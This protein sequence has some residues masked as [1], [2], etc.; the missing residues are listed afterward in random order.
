[1]ETNGWVLA[2]MAAVVGAAAWA[3][4]HVWHRRRLAAL[5]LRLEKMDRARQAA[6]QQVLQLRKQIEK[7]QK[8]LVD[9]RRALSLAAAH[10]EKS[11]QREAVLRAGNLVTLHD[12]ANETGT[13]PARGFEDTMPM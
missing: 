11:R 4:S 13:R 8:D 10:R 3:A 1:M 5:S 7:L 12:V 6:H 2:A 9:S